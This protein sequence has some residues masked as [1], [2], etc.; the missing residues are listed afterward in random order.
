MSLGK[1]TA[2]E[3]G[4]AGFANLDPAGSIIEDCLETLGIQNLGHESSA[5]VGLATC[6]PMESDEDLTSFVAE[7]G[8]LDFVWMFSQTHRKSTTPRL[9]ITH[10]PSDSRL[11]FAKKTS[12]HL[13]KYVQAQPLGSTLNPEFVPFPT[14][15]QRAGKLSE[16]SPLLNHRETVQIV[17]DGVPFEILTDL[18]ENS[19]RLVVFGQDAL[20][21]ASAP[22]PRFFRWKW[23]PDVAASVVIVND[24][25][26]YLDEDLDGA[27]WIGS[28]SRDYVEEFVPILERI[29]EAVGAEAQSVLFAGFSAGGFSAFQMASRLP[30]SSVMVD[31]PRVTMLAAGAR[32]DAA[33]KAIRSCLGFESVSSV[34][35]EYLKRIDVTER[36]AESSSI[37]RFRYFQNLRDASHLESQYRRFRSAIE[38]DPRF[39]ARIHKFV[40]YSQY[41][42]TKGG[43][44]P[45]HRDRAISEINSL[46]REMS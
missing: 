29:M 28:Q 15:H 33:E 10:V 25:T 12:R 26:L 9:K 24:P 36:L 17:Q 23:T 27:W 21:R 41:H 30:G 22:L 18:R 16:Y 39:D 42:L 13:E 46:L 34:P 20:S 45:M 4:V 6:T 32:S 31:I 14:T 40:E 8:E 11:A 19:G 7:H 2:R 37:P 35:R 1:S 43:H 5:V 38:S 3:R 44:F